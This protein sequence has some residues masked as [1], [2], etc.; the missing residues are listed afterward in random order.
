MAHGLYAVLVVLEINT[1]GLLQLL[2]G[3]EVPPVLGWIQDPDRTL[4][5]TLLANAIPDA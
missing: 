3:P 1:E 2:A 5:M 4:K